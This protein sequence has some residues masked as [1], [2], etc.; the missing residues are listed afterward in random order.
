[1]FTGRVLIF[2]TV[3]T[4]QIGDIGTSQMLVPQNKIQHLSFTHFCEIALYEDMQ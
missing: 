2:H 4:E 1:M 3:N